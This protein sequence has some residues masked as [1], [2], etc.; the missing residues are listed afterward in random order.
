MTWPKRRSTEHLICK[1]ADDPDSLSN[2]PDEESQR[3]GGMSAA[4]E[5]KSYSVICI[6]L[7]LRPSRAKAEVRE[8]ENPKKEDDTVVATVANRIRG[9]I[10]LAYLLDIL[11]PG[12]QVFRVDSSVLPAERQA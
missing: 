10:S 9:F 7:S 2:W 5:K 12:L 4:P 6:L 3:K 1:T 11:H 8:Q